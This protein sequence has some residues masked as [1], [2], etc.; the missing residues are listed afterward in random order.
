LLMD[1]AFELSD[2]HRKR[3]AFDAQPAEAPVRRGIGFASFMHGAGFTGSGEQYLASEAATEATPEGRVQVLAGS[4]EIGQGAN[5]IL[6][7]IAAEALHVPYEQIDILQPDTARVRTSGP[8]VASRTT[9]IVGKLV[10]TAAQQ[11]SRQLIDAG[12]LPEDYSPEDFSRACREFI[13]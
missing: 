1:R 5:T 8:T 4:T 13:A 7:Q 12:L 3:A 11:I 10:E 6:A 2:Y 9:M